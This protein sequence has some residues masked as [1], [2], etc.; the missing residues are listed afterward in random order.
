MAAKVLLGNEQYSSYQGL[1][2]PHAFTRKRET[3]NQFHRIY[4]VKAGNRIVMAESQLESDAV[5]W[6]EAQSDVVSICEQPMRIQGSIGKK[7][8]Y[9][10]DLGLVRNSGE[11][12]FYEIKPECQLSKNEEGQLET[13][14]WPI[15]KAWCKEKG[16]TCEI[17]TDVKLQEN[18]QLINNWRVLLGFVRMS[19]ED[20]D[21]E[22]RASVLRHIEFSEEITTKTVI[23]HVGNERSQQVVAVVA[24]L[25]M[26]E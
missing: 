24:S 22:L 3:S 23:N 9:T 6:A 15:I 10:F 20:N 21:I 18:T 19:V 4:S 13:A 12:V 2:G 25:H 14:D 16:H 5:Y 8:Y 26:T 11:E 17:L 7:P 1:R